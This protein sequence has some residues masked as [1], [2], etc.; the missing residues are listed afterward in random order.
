MDLL[1]RMDELRRS[2]SFALRPAHRRCGKLG[3]RWYGIGSIQSS[4][5][6]RSAA[7]WKSLPNRNVFPRAQDLVRWLRQMALQAMERHPR[8]SRSSRHGESQNHH[9]AVA[10]RRA[11]F[12]LS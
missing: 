10:T 3:D 11:R 7:D 6:S 4:K 9:Q 12:G 5:L 2:L 1:V 8:R